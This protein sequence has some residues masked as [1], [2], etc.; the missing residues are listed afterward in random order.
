MS[1]VCPASGGPI[2]CPVKKWAKE[3]AGGKIPISSPRTPYLKRR[4]GPGP[5]RIPAAQK[6]AARLHKA[7]RIRRREASPDASVCVLRLCSDFDDSAFSLS[8][9]SLT[10]SLPEGAMDG[11]VCVPAAQPEIR[12]EQGLLTERIDRSI[13]TAE[14]FLIVRTASTEAS[15]DSDALTKEKPT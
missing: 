14:S 15:A 13:M 1:A 2:S 11:R 12:P 4:K 10:S 5:L 6:T 3:T 8:L 9:A 7:D